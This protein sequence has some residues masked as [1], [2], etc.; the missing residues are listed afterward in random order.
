[1]EARKL[2]SQDGTYFVLYTLEKNNNYKQHLSVFKLSDNKYQV[3][4]DKIVG[5]KGIK[6]IESIKLSDKG[7]VLDA[8]EY[9]KSDGLCCP[10][11][12]T[13]IIYTLKGNKLDET[14]KMNSKTVK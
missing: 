10:S 9:A 3:I 12:P 6:S 5:G 4:D 8:K 11:I 1:M 13:E 7:I 14:N 2:Q